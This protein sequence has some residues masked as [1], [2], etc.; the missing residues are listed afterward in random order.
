MFSVG[1]GILSERLVADTKAFLGR[2]AK[3]VDAALGPQ[4]IY[5]FGS[6]VYRDGAQFNDRSDIDLVVVAPEIPDAID[7]ASWFEAFVPHKI[8]LE[9]TLGK[10]LRRADRG[11]ILSS[12]V[13]TTSIEVTA[14]IHKDGAAKF[15]SENRFL[16]LLTGQIVDGLPDAGTR[17]VTERLVGECLRFVQKTRNTY[18]GY[19]ALSDTQ[20]APF[21]DAQDAAP[22]QAM[23]HAAMV[24]SLE[25]DGD[26]DPGAEFDLDIGANKLTLLLYD[27]RKRLADLGA[28]YAARRGGRAKREALS[29]NDQLILAE[30]VFDAAIQAE[31]R[32]AGAAKPP[33][34]P[35]MGGAHSTVVFAERFGDA[36]P[37]VRGIEWFNEQDSI[38][39]RLARL[40]A[41]PLEY[42]D[43]T[44]LWWTRG[45]SNL[46]ITSYAEEGSHILLNGDEMNVSRIAAV[47]QASY[48]YSFVYVEVEPLAPIGIYKTTAARIQE[49]EDGTSYSP[50]YW[51][52]YGLVDGKH[53]ITR[54]EADDGSAMIDG[55]LQ[56][57]R[58]RLEVRGRHVTKYNFIVAA[59]GAP[60]M[61]GK[62]DRLLEAHLNA[63][64]KGQDKLPDIAR[65]STRLSTGRY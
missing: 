62:Y 26:G 59:A 65:E 19:N 49:V 47:N 48:K 37:G 46:Q 15:F 30:L 44:P 64:L 42:D 5:L 57:L 29:A 3:E 12:V 54:A 39:Q 25:D 21:D 4:A 8:S 20:L 45:P 14:N 34:K 56:S 53:F 13:A 58:G 9:D 16:D 28:R 11:T 24:Q 60:L 2:W 1:E 22:K 40:F 23:R 33:K 18:L 55:K 7:R 38:R 43:G 41:P 17:N 51:E 63:M 31:T 36:F 32:A 6:L 61:N 50:Y 35:T 27:R 10:I 52:E